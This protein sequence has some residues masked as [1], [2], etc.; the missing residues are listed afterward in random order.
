M[1]LTKD[2]KLLVLYRR[3]VEILTELHTKTLVPS[4]NGAIV[5]RMF[6]SPGR[7]QML[8]KELEEVRYTIEMME[9]DAA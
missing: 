2:E 1:G 3:R 8:R 7:E 9:D 6:L 4:V 5:K